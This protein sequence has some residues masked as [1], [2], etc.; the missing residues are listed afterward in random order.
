[1]FTLHTDDA[2]FSY[3]KLKKNVKT[4]TCIVFRNP[5]NDGNIITQGRLPDKK[6]SSQ[7]TT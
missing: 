6:K 4:Y 5:A 3:T 2:L 7:N 1:M